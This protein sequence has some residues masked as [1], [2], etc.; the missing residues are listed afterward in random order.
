MAE[1]DIDRLFREQLGHREFPYDPTMWDEVAATLFA[2]R[3]RR[4]LLWW[5]LGGLLAGSLCFWLAWS[6]FRLSANGTA[7]PAVAELPIPMAPAPDTCPEAAGLAAANPATLTAPSPEAH[8]LPQRRILRHQASPSPAAFAER[9]V[10]SETEVTAAP[11]T[12][13]PR[14]DRLAAL[15]VAG[16]ALTP[17]PAT[18]SA[19]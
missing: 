19:P 12:S 13:A 18:A 4:L 15:P 16:L 17:L 2:K 14:R 5:W 7:E 9:Q 6:M 11:L 3:R 1:H 10:E 8:A